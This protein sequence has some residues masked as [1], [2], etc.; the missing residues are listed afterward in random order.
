MKK[1]LKIRKGDITKKVIKKAAIR[2]REVQKKDT[3]MKTIKDTNTSMVM[4]LTNHTMKSMER[5]VENT[6]EV[7]MVK[8][9]QTFIYVKIIYSHPLITRF[10][11][12]RW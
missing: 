8:Y 6:V 9:K 3:M 4:N 11:K 12:R 7:S 10:Q 5:K 2:K 1:K